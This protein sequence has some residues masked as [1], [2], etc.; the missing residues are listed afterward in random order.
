MLPV[1]LIAVLL[2]VTVIVVIFITRD[3][4]D[5]SSGSPLQVAVMTWGGAGPGFVGIEK[6]FFG[7]LEVKLSVIDDSRARQAAFD[8]AGFEI[9]L[10]N[11]DQHPR[12]RQMGLPGRMVLLSDVSMGADGVIAHPDI[13]SISDLRGKEVVYV[14]GSASDF[15]IS[16]ALESAGLSR[17]DVNLIAVEDPSVSVAALKNGQVAAAVSWEPIMSQAVADGQAKILFTSRDVPGTILGVFVAKDALIDN[18]DRF[19]AFMR[20]WL[21][22]VDYVLANPEESNR[23]MAAAFSVTES[24]MAEMMAGLELMDT[25]RNA[26]WFDASNGVSRLD[27][28]ANETGAY[29]HSLGLL[30]EEPPRDKRWTDSAAAAL[31]SAMSKE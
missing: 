3:G 14:R 27:A 17:S 7:D 2:V 15:M 25:E 8:S 29:W 26:A 24:E 13:E 10:T 1:V 4:K 21:Q 20:G 23:I 12:E 22:S 9:L 18:S 5:E 19:E 6:G 31:L 30:D 16:K 11:P 28:F